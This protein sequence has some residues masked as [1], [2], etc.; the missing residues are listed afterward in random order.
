MTR[1]RHYSK[2]SSP[3]SSSYYYLNETWKTICSRFRGRLVLGSGSS[4][5]SIHLAYCFLPASA[6][7]CHP[8]N[9]EALAGIAAAASGLPWKVSLFIFNILIQKMQIIIYKLNMNFSE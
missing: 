5:S 4:S 8:M 2:V 3:I 1:R 9:A 7:Y 6:Q